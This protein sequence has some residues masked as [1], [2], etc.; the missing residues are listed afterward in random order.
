[1]NKQPTDKKKLKRIKTGQFERRASMTKAGMVAGSRMAASSVANLF[2]G[3]EKRAERQQAL[4]SKQ[5]HY[6]AE[7]LGELKGSVVK[8]G[9]M[10]AL[11]GEHFLPEEV[12]EALHTLE[13]QT[14][15]LEWQTI[16]PILREQLGDQFDEFEFDPEPLGAASIGQ[17]HRGRRKADSVEL[18]FKIQYPGVAAA[19]DT[20]L[21]AMATLLK[22]SKLVP[23][24]PDFER[25][26]DEVR[27]MLRREVD[28]EVELS[29]TKRFAERLKHDQRF[30]VPKVYPEY[31]T[32]TLMV[33]SY[34]P[35]VAPGSAVSLKLSLERRNAISEAALDLFFQEFYQWGELQTDPNFGNYRIRLDEHGNDRLVLLDFGAVRQFPKAF[36]N[37]F[38]DV[39]A[40]AAMRNEEQLLRGGIGLNFLNRTLPQQVMD[41]F[42]AVS[43]QVIEPFAEHAKYPPP[44]YALNADM[45]YCWKASKLPKRVAAQAGKAAISKHFHVPPQEFVFLI[46][47]LVGVYT[48]M[49]AMDAQ[50]N[51][52]PILKKYIGQPI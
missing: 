39:V 11:Y 23:I 17:V 28:Y 40:G 47:K 5:A 12:T 14:V 7:Q 19:V 41:D 8:A 33:S 29:T 30:I 51:G 4:M 38:H 2:S 35:G 21:D 26:L 22:L 18:C 20:D 25:W 49:A 31:S 43:F 37:N 24:T 45:Q 50:F 34:E 13:D 6:L 46:R 10:M 32:P 15:A 16:E 52:W 44:D 27:V 3:K 9:Q 36:L 1:M 42:V 48:F